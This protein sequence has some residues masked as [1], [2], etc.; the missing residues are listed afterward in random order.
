MRMV[1]QTQ[2]RLEA[3]APNKIQSCKGYGDRNI[4]LSMSQNRFLTC[5]G[6]PLNI[7]FDKLHCTHR[8][9]CCPLTFAV[10]LTSKEFQDQAAT[11]ERIVV[12]RVINAYQHLDQ[13]AQICLR[14]NAQLHL[15]NTQGPARQA[16]LTC[17]LMNL[18]IR[19]ICK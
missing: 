18:M 10:P 5:F 6:K 12:S 8:V 3:S 15:H 11:S 9:A 14:L 2:V 16:R 1:K 17:L 7:M 13:A 19:M 4:V